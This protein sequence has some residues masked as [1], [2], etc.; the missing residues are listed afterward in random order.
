M[1]RKQGKTLEFWASLKFKRSNKESGL[2]DKN[3]IWDHPEWNQRTVLFE[4]DK[5]S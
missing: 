4:K 5:N 3:T 2:L 1:G